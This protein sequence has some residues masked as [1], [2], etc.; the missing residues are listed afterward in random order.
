M[1]LTRISPRHAFT[2]S[3]RVDFM[4]VCNYWPPAFP[5]DI[6]DGEVGCIVAMTGKKRLRIKVPIR[7]VERIV[8]E[9]PA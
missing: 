5:H 7:I 1:K 2:Y 9:R 4:P 3:R 6:L 8:L